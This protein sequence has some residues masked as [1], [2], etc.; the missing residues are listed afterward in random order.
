MTTQPSAAVPRLVMLAPESFRGRKVEL[1]TDYLTV[2]REPTCDVCLDDPHV[3]RTHAALQRR[4]GTVYVQD[5]GSSGGTFVNGN[6]AT[7][8]ELRQGDVI[9]F[10]SVQAWFEAAPP[11]TA[12]TQAM[13]TQAGPRAGTASPPLG[14]ASPGGTSGA[15]PEP[16]PTEFPPVNAI[17]T[18]QDEGHDMEPTTLT[19]SPASRWDLWLASASPYL[20]CTRS[21]VRPPDPTRTHRMRFVAGVHG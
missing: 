2:G 11:V 19:R 13:P 5:L 6:P 10:A 7:K 1:A 17:A 20:C 8:A 21:S 15:R 14:S 18:A 3:S 4:G 9:T 12:E 16:N